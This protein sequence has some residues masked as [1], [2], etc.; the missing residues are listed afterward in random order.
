MRRNSRFPIAAYTNYLGRTVRQVR[1]EAA[2]REAL[3]RYVQSNEAALA[4]LSPLKVHAAL[5]RFVE[6]EKSAA[7]SE[8]FSR[9][10][11]HP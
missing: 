11:R 7:P 6:A 4:G 9:N 10:R 5:R 3:E 2:L 8:A 1:E